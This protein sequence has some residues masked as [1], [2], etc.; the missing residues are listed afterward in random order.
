MYWR[1]AVLAALNRYS[2]RHGTYSVSRQDLIEEE[3]EQ[4]V[5][6]TNSTG[7]TPWQTLSRILQEL[8]EER[9]IFFTSQGKYL[10]ASDKI[11]ITKEDLP[12]DAID[13]AITTNK[14]TIANFPTGEVALVARQRRGQSRV[15]YI[16]LENYARRCAF[17]DIDQPDLLI[18]S[19]IARW[20]DMPE[21]RGDLHNVICMCSFH[22]ALF[23]HGYFS[24]TDDYR[25]RRKLIRAGRML[26]AVLDLT[27]SF[28]APKAFSPTSHYLQAHRVRTGLVA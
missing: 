10:L 22:D 2:Q 1:E 19:H 4:I 24:L 8:R 16:A 5:K 15:R 26:A 21:G 12:D 9:L 6:D 18:A 23:E 14:L 25:I 7:A 17:C 20:A 3:L 27:Q 11:E 13:F 28:R